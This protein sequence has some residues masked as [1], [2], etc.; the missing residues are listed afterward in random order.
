MS[1]RDELLRVSRKTF[2]SRRTRDG[3]VVTE[4]RE[5]Q[6]QPV[7]SCQKPHNSLHNRFLSTQFVLYQNSETIRVRVMSF[8]NSIGCVI[9]PSRLCD[10]QFDLAIHTYRWF[11]FYDRRRS[12]QR[13]GP[14]GPKRSPTPTSATFPNATS[15]DAAPPVSPSAPAHGIQKPLYLCS[16]FVEAALVKGNF[17][18]IVML[19]KYV[20]I[21][22]WVAVNSC[23]HLFP[24]FTRLT[25][26]PSRNPNTNMKFST[27]SRIL[28]CSMELYLNAAHNSLVQ[29][30]PL[31]PREC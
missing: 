11:L 29:A 5:Q 24:A 6:E 18:T 1:R 15:T 19:P 9:H 25:A 31:V 27:S 4:T 2:A 8:F 7:E 3:P 20:D 10:V 12:M 21:M 28:I 22:E 17:K 26:P 14:R 30:C 13:S 16:P 23:V